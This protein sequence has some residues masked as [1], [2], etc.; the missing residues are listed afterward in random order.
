MFWICTG[1]LSELVKCAPIMWELVK[2]KE[3]YLW[4]HLGHCTS[5]IMFTQ[6]AFTLVGKKPDLSLDGPPLRLGDHLTAVRMA[7]AALAQH[8]MPDVIVVQGDTTTVLAAAMFG[9]A[10][11]IRIAHMEAGLRSHDLMMP[12]EVIRT[13]VDSCATWRFAPTDE[14][15][16]NL[17][18][19]M[20]DDGAH[21]VG[22]TFVESVTKL[23]EDADDSIVT[24]YGLV[25]GEYILATISQP[26]NIDIK[27]RCIRLFECI[28]ALAITKKIY[29]PIHP[30]TKAK[31]GVWGIKR[32]NVNYVDPLP[33]LDFMTLERSAKLIITD[34]GSVQEEACFFGVPCALLRR[35]TERPET[36]AMGAS[37]LIDLDLVDR[38]GFTQAVVDSLKAHSNWSHPYGTHASELIVDALLADLLPEKKE[39]KD[40]K[41][42]SGEGTEEDRVV[43]RG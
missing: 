17:A 19:E 23:M 10:S 3:P 26:E 27:Q 13:V 12:E 42:E 37:K 34:S 31:M 18:S 1:T 25:P 33:T 39:N 22:A 4:L 24:S 2:R 36:I 28:E 14:A 21:M 20:N 6:M 43:D 32:T 30:E 41:G 11:G 5:D 7:M 8:G 29:F 15:M 38:R 16:T 9:M 35:S 40:G